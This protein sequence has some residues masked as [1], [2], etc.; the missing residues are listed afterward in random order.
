MSFDGIADLRPDVEYV[1][2]TT[3]GSSERQ[4]IARDR[5]PSCPMPEL[6]ELRCAYCGRRVAPTRGNCVG[7]GAPL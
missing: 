5:A 3:V 1:E 7:C 4:F 2:V 6:R